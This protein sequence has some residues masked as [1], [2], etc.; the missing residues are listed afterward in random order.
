MPKGT[1]KPKY[2]LKDMW[3][4]TI[5]VNIRTYLRGL[6]NGQGPELTAEDFWPSDLDAL[7]QAVKNNMG[8][9]PVFGNLEND[10]MTPRPD[11]QRTKG[12]VGYGDYETPETKW[13]YGNPLRTLWKSYTDPAFRMETTLGNSQYELQDGGNIKITDAYDFNADRDLTRQY[14][15]DKGTLGGI[16]GL[17]KE[18]ALARGKAGSLMNMLGNARI[19]YDDEAP[20][21]SFDV[22]SSLGAGSKVNK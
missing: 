8:P 15:E 22:P 1:Q 10:E 7:R 18:L 4:A 12:Q 20:V 14:M 2:D 13:E 6:Y 21:F 9:T 19:G 17:L 5:P 16:M 3:R 11:W